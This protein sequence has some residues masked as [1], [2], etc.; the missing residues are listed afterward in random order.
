MDIPECPVN[1]NVTRAKVLYNVY[2]CMPLFACVDKHDIS[3]SHSLL[4]CGINT[5]LL[6]HIHGIN[7]STTEAFVYTYTFH[8]LENTLH[9]NRDCYYRE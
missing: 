6:V 1:P 8:T 3:L 2:V 4:Q 9:L 5:H 7:T